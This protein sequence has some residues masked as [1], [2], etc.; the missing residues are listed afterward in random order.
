VRDFHWR[1]YVDSIQELQGA[2]ATDHFTL[3]IENHGYNRAD[4]RSS[5]LLKPTETSKLGN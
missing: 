5:I 3:T 1:H 4:G 2:N